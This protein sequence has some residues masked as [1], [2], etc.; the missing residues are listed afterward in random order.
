MENTKDFILDNKEV[1][2][3]EISDDVTSLG[4]KDVKG[5]I[6][7][8]EEYKTNPFRKDAIIHAQIGFKSVKIGT[9]ET[10][11]STETGQIVEGQWHYQKQL[12]DKATFVKIYADQIH[13][14]YEL[15]KPARKLFEYIA[16]NLQPNA[17]EIYIMPDMLVELCGYKARN[18]VYKA[19]VVLCKKGIIGK[20]FRPYWWFIN[21]TVL[22][23][24]SRVTL[25]NDYILQTKVE[26][27]QW[28]D[29]MKK[30]L[31]N[32]EE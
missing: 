16:T 25:I 5:G 26:D 9:T 17:D 21:P 32:G 8:L 30:T 4:L 29:D 2:T 13:K 27:K 19:L 18:Q 3:I 23:N 1:S 7:S 28:G 11:V 15:P 14:I 24:G 22:F 31:S 6:T 20:S 10:L 12:V